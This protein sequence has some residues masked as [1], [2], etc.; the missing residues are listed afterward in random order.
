[1][2]PHLRVNHSRP[3][4]QRIR[5]PEPNLRSRSAPG[6]TSIEEIRAT[7]GRRKRELLRRYTRP[8][9]RILDVGCGAG[10]YLLAARELGFEAMGVEPSDAHATIGRGLGLDIRSGYYRPGD[11]AEGGFDLV[12][13]SHVVEHIYDP[14]PFLESLAGL[15]R[16]GGWLVAITPDSDCLPARLSGKHWVMLKPIDHVSMLTE[17]ALRRMGLERYGNVAFRRTSQDG[18][19]FITLAAAARDAAQGIHTD[20][21]GG[22]AAVAGDGAVGAG[23]VKHALARW[24]RSVD[25]VAD[26]VNRGACLIMELQRT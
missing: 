12:L 9:A 15:V 8:G 1:M 21:S 5:S 13:T 22:Q 10:G 17:R 7:A 26:R 25:R 16:P 11:F 19:F 23:R 3:I 4:E 18:E 20:A 2:V 14:R 6:S 24:A